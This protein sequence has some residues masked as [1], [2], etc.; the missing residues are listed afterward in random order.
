VGL[1]GPCS[2]RVPAALPS[3]RGSP[4]GS[5]RLRAEGER[6]GLTPGLALR[7]AMG[8]AGRPEPGR[9]LQAWA[10]P[11]GTAPGLRPYAG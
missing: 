11:R 1:P 6:E 4:E 2:D 7:R 9:T 3:G 5:L 10:H 8:A